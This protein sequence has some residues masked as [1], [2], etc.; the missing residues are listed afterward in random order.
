MKNSN[1]C[2][3]YKGTDRGVC[4]SIDG[5]ERKG[6]GEGCWLRLMLSVSALTRVIMSTTHLVEC[7]AERLVVVERLR[8]DAVVLVALV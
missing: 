4:L 2:F 1:T 5:P 6:K 8:D 3:A 7:V